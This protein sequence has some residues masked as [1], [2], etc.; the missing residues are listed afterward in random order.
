[1]PPAEGG[2]R[3]DTRAAM[4]TGGQTGPA[5]VPGDPD[6]SLLIQV[7]RRTHDEIA[8]PPDE[9]LDKDEIDSL[10][11]WVQAGAPWPDDAPADR[12]K[13]DEH[14]ITQQEREFWSFQPIDRPPVPHVDGAWG[15]HP[16]DAFLAKQQQTRKLSRVNRASPRLLLRRLSYDLL[17]LP[18]APAEL[19][20]FEQAAGRD[21]QHAVKYQIDRMLQ[22]QHYGERW[23]QHWLDLVRYADTAGDAADYPI[24]EAYK[25]RNYVIEAFQSDKPFDQFVR[26]QIAGDLMPATS[27]TQ[28]WKQTVATGYVALSRRV[29]VVPRRHIIIEDTLNNVGK[30][31]LGLTIGCARCHDHKFDPIPTAD[32]Y[33][34]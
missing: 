9:H 4:T 12:A 3:L 7:V 27:E 24:P 6:K 21:W 26:E 29:G 8:M 17:G 34:L 14:G 11:R 1:M 31:F 10:V 30:T 19:I 18:P 20:E 28:T 2:L 5:I 33:A 16:I 25:Y 13:P 23:A 32:Y 22:S 15:K